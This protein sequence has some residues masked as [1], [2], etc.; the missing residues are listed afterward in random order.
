MAFESHRAK[1][2]SEDIRWRMIYQRY[3]MG[4]SYQQIADNLCVDVSTVWRAVRKFDNEGSVTTRY[5]KGPQTL[6]N[7]QM[8]AIIECVLENPDIYLKE[9]SKHLLG[10]T[11]STVSESSICRFLQRN[12]FSRKKLQHIAQ[13]RNEQLRALFISD[14]ALYSPEMMVF[15]DETGCD[16]RDSMRKYGYALR[17]HRATARRLLCRGKRVSSVAAIDVNG[18][19][20][21][22]STLETINGDF[23]CDFLERFLL[24]QLLPFDGIN[25]KSV[26][27]L[28]NASIHHVPRAISLIQSV[29]ALVH[30]LPAYSPDLNPIEELFSKIKA[31]LKENDHAIQRLTDDCTIDTVQAA[32]SLVTPDD[33]YGWYQHSGYI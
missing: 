5:S 17:G 11:G 21:V 1:A 13:Q 29:G 12:K 22:K 15:L 16:N 28:D 26:V 6:T 9:I 14:C 27:L 25:P 20:C 10:T 3:M 32:Y 19:L 24:P 31:V 18:V 4:L 2:Y 30:F 23:F 7:D 33:C 8:F